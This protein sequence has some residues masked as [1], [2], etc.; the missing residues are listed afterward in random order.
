MDKTAQD[1]LWLMKWILDQKDAQAIDQIKALAD[2]IEYDRL[3]DAKVIGY[4]LNDLPITKSRFMHQV[5]QSLDG[6]EK[7]EYITYADLEKAVEAW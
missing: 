2:D 7:G 3:S 5:K 4:A 6:M 1:K